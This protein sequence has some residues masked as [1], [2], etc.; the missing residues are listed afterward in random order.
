MNEGNEEREG[1]EIAKI[2]PKVG[3]WDT[4]LESSPV[5]LSVERFGYLL[6]DTTEVNW[7]GPYHLRNR[8]QPSPQGS[9]ESGKGVEK[10][11][12]VRRDRGVTGT[13]GRRND[14]HGRDKRNDGERKSH[15]LQGPSRKQREKRRTIWKR[16][17]L[18]YIR[19]QIYLVYWEFR[20]SRL[21]LE[22]RLGG[23]VDV[24]LKLFCRVFYFT[25]LFL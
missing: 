17:L 20:H 15:I 3:V 18:E 13:K 12:E 19:F 23:S 6:K 11:E 25:G 5:T 8:V 21:G 22:W 4:F 9:C 2:I 24:D 16:D 10:E 1:E 14:W 7:R